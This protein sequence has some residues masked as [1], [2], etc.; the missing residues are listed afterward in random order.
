MN[1]SSKVLKIFEFLKYSALALIPILNI[2]NGIFIINFGFIFVILFAVFEI[3]INRGIVEFNREFL[4]F[5][6]VMIGLNIIT[7]FLHLDYLDIDAV[8]NNTFYMVI[9]TLVGTY[10]AKPSAVDRER[11]Y[12]YLVVIGIFCTLFLFVQ[13][14][15]YTK[16]IVLYGYIPGLEV[17]GIEDTLSVSI[18]YGR[19]TSFFT[20]PAHYA[21]FILPVYAMALYR[22]QT[23]LSIL[24]LAGLI[25]S[26]SSTG[27]M[28]AIIITTIFIFKKTKISII[29]KWVMLLVGV[30]IFIQFLPELNE[31]AV[32]DKVKFVNLKSNVRIFGTLEYFK[33]FGI[34]EMFFGAGLNRFSHFLSRYISGGV[35]NYANAA[36]YA[37]FSFGLIGG[38]I[39]TYYIVR[40]HKLSKFK[41][42]YLSFI[43]VYVTDQI[44]FNRNFL[45]L[46]LLLYIYSDREDEE[47]P[48]V[49]ARL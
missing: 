12:K 34:K 14:F 38:S 40:L 3:F 19:P 43:I 22:R 4:L 21:I 45:Y 48:W 9:I 24:F 41:M 6:S 11:F 23:F 15:L 47:T 26:T 39:L 49:E 13:A 25:V 33:Y 8:M 32:F 27:I 18:S 31:S 10:F 37:F 1:E 29:L 36:F 30:F 7:G 44:L 16:G 5:M 35:Q 42:I 28:G 17:E 46:V 20:E 2:Y